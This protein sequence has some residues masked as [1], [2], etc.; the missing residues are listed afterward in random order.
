MPG[1][2]LLHISIQLIVPAVVERF[3]LLDPVRKDEAKAAEDTDEGEV[4]GTISIFI[5]HIEHSG[6]MQQE[7]E[8]QTEAR[9]YQ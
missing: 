9:S 8:E 4:D 6:M 7:C 3:L 5:M 2:T 1:F